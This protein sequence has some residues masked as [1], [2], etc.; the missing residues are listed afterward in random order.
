MW[1]AA[2][3]GIRNCAFGAIILVAS[4]IVVGGMTDIVPV[5]AWKPIVEFFRRGSLLLF[6]SAVWGARTLANFRLILFGTLVILLLFYIL[7]RPQLEDH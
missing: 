1:E 2:G 5:V 4:A 6:A 7:T 3:K